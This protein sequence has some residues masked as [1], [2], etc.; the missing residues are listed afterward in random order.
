MHDYELISYKILTRTQN[1]EFQNGLW[2][3]YDFLHYSR[4]FQRKIL[5]YFPEIIFLLINSLF[6]DIYFN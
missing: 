3:E 1:L 6:L 5:R 4:F 2:H